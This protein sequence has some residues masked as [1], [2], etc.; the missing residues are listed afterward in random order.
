[1]WGGWTGGKLEA[2]TESLAKVCWNVGSR[3]EVQ[4]LGEETWT[5]KYCHGWV[6]EGLIVGDRQGNQVLAKKNLDQ[7][8]HLSNHG[9]NLVGQHVG[10]RQ[11]GGGWRLQWQQW[12]SCHHWTNG[13]K[14]A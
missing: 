1:M 6:L 7:L 13:R 11:L 2:G 10:F 8:F 14:P 12:E 5:G 9:I 4:V 3:V